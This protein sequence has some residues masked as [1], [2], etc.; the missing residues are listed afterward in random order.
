MKTDKELVMLKN[1]LMDDGIHY[2]VLQERQL[3]LSIAKV[4]KIF[5]SILVQ[6]EVV[7]KQSSSLM[8]VLVIKYLLL[9]LNMKRLKVNN[10][11]A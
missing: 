7:M 9:P 8:V 10:T 5:N 3:Q 2:L 4:Q 1:E 11:I 6:M